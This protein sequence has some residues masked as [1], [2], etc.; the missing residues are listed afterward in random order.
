MPNIKINLPELGKKRVVVIGGGFAGLTL[1]QKLNTQKFQVVLLDRNNY[2]QFQPLFYQVA[3]AGLEPSSIVFPFRKFFQNQQVYFR[4]AEVKEINPAENRILTSHG[5][6]NYDYLVLAAGTKTHYFGNRQIQQHCLPIKSVSEALFLRNRILED[7]E[8]AL[9]CP[10]PDQRSKYL[11]IVIV[12]GGP[13]GVELAGALAEMRKHILPKDYPEMNPSEVQIIL[14]ESGNR[15]LKSMSSKASQAAQA[16]LGKQNVVI[17]LNQRVTSYDGEWLQTSREEAISTNKV[18]WAAGVRGAALPG[19]P[20]SALSEAS[21]YVVNQRLQVGEFKNI[22]AIGDIALVNEPEYP[23]GHPQVAQVAIQQ[24][25]YLSK[26]LPLYEEG[27]TPH[28]F[29]YRDLGSL[30]TV[31]RHAAIADISG[32]FFKGIPAWYLWLFVHLKGLLGIKN[33]LFVLLNW[34]WSYL[35]YDQPLR[36]IIRPRPPTPNDSPEEANKLL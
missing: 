30:A 25:L 32:W 16:Y 6:V 35:T 9:T 31:G 28:D 21:R 17:R 4:L 5:I 18:I 7:Y 13:T 1:T 3:M 20:A 24:A 14:I 23:Q 10:D 8:T 26:T 27:K 22:F 11:T 34:L 19:L 36:V 29:K 15:L 33:K 12:G 2:H